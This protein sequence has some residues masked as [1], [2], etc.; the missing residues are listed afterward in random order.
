[1]R[2]SSNMLKRYIGKPLT[3]EQLYETTNEYITEVESIE[4]LLE[5]DNFVVGHV[6]KSERH[7]N[8]DKLSVCLVDIGEDEPEQ[9]VCGAPNVKAGQYVGVAKVGSILPGDFEIKS[10]TIRG[11]ESNGMITSL[12]ELGFGDKF[13]APDFED[14]IFYFDEEKELGSSAL[15]ALALDQVSLELDVTPN[16]ADLLSV[17]GYAYD[18]A[19]ALDIEVNKVEPKVV[20]TGPKNPVNITIL[21]EGCKR[22][23]A[24]YLDNIKVGPSPLWMQADLIASGIRP[25]NNVVDVTNYVLME[26][27]TPLHAFDALKFET[28]EIVVKRATDLEE[29]ITLDEQIRILRKDDI[30]ITNGKEVVALGGVMGLLNTMVDNNTTKIILEA[31]SFDSKRVRNTSRRLDLISDSS[32]R[33]ERGIDEVRVRTAINRA[34]EL[35]VE[36]AGARVYEDINFRGES[37]EKP[38]IISITP[39]EVNKNLGTELT[40]EEIKTILRRLNIIETKPDT[41]LIPTY[42]NDL[43]IPVDLV[44]EIG[45]IYGFNNI[46]TTLPKS[47]NLGRYSNYQTFENQIRKRFK[48]LGFNEVIN[49]SLGD[50][51]DIDL[52]RD[53][54][55]TPVKLLHPLRD[56][57]AYLRHSLINGLVNTV[58][59]NLSRQHENLSL[60][61]VG[62]IYYEDSEPLYM[63]AI[64]QGK[65]IDGTFTNQNIGTS[66]YLTKGFLEDLL[67]EYNVKVDY[68]KEENVKGFHPGV[69]ARVLLKG[70]T[71]GF[72]GAIHPEI[73]EDAFAFEINLNLLHKHIEDQEKYE[74]ISRFPSISRDIAIV[75]DDNIEASKISELI[76]QTT[77]RFLTNIEVFDLYK[78]KRLGDNKV[79]IGFRMT[80][81]ST[82]KTLKTKDVDKMMNSVIFRLQKEF[83][84]EIRQ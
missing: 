20:E 59:Y 29:V 75:V 9:I 60:F 23:Y 49:Y 41:Y 3:K 84:A 50:I 10:A 36:V 79:S 30:V 2:I 58:N 81:S 33:F 51:K 39:L 66:F 53:A 83:N 47:E 32:L 74:L 72:V 14:G 80:F 28:N 16:R 8:A 69:C 62:N 43:K 4:T 54:G 64:L 82:E 26:L 19:A 22:Y 12:D 27:G 45:R 15:S 55:P 38:S 13:V 76:E 46:P 17:L 42:R 44:E 11:V 34:A 7:P 67:N 6:L 31:A 18:L 77:R 65:Y 25:I 70:E 68:V 63:A 1:M 78:D 35:L 21:D 57:R 52:Y 5:V 37:F 40:K 61:E 71:L 48:H 56:D 73:L 24:R